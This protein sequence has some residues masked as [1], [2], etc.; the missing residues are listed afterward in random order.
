MTVK[1]SIRRILVAV[2]DLR[3]R[4]SPSLKKAAR[5]ARALQ[6]RVELFHVMS[7][8]VAVDALAFAKQGLVAFEKKQQARALQ[9]LEAMAEP[10]R[11]TGLDVTVAAEWDF[12]VH[13][14]VVRRALRSK[15][16]LIVA[17]RHE[18]RHV[19]P[20]LLRYADWELLRH[21]PVPVLLVKTRRDYAAP[22]IL[23][24]IDPSHAF[25]KTAGLDQRILHLGAELS[26]KTR[27]RLHALHAFV[28]SLNDVPTTDLTQPDATSRIVFGAARAAADRFGKTL[29]AARLGS[30]PPGRRHLVEQHPA[31]AILRTAQ[32]QG[33][34][35]VVMGLVRNGLKGLFIGNSA[36]QIVDQLACD[37]LIVKPR[38]FKS[39]VPTRIRGPQLVSIGPPYGAV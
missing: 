38:G 5:L 18:G 30:L 9:R 37:L 11:R 7:E 39:R 26:Q 15:A 19:A 16:D 32:Q 22:K 29:R 2:K 25:A 28:P 31:D 34:D 21:S 17:E 14:A 12:P 4:S 27:G 6:A 1:Q 13:E 24:A 20:W 35:I 33:I 10:L 23:A 8:P 3:G 36:E